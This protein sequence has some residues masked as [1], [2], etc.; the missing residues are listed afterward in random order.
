MKTKLEIKAEIAA[1][2]EEL[3]GYSEKASRDEMT[4]ELYE[5]M[6]ICRG[7]KQALEWVLKV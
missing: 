2:D 7:W 5:E 4:S 3:E 6:D 1:C